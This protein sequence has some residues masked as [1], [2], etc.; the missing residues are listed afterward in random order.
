MKSP[1]WRLVLAALVFGVSSN[2]R[3][4]SEIT[5]LAPTPIRETLD[6]LVEGFTAKTAVHVKVTY[7]SGVGTRKTVASGRALDVSLL[8]APFPEALETGNIDPPSATVIARLRLAIAVRKGAPKPDIS[9]AAAVRRAL[10]NAK[11]IAS[12][13]PVQGSVGGAVLLALDKMGITDQV[14]P[15]VR[16]VATGG[17][18]QDLAAKGEVELAFGPYLS[19]MRNPGLE[20]VGALPPE[21][22]TPVDITGFLSTGVKDAKAARAL[23]DYLASR[24]AA[25]A[26]TAA[27][28]FPV[29]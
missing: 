12:V 16:W 15:K 20:V 1:A 13:D 2:A 8:F 26:Y 5:L 21:A 27:K 14:K 9:T 6:P 22:A 4:Q 19:D 25:P 28:M 17:V 29:R 10:V 24:E 7:G 18:V 3:A 11:S 23:L